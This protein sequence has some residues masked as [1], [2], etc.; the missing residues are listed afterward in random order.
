MRLPGHVASSHVYLIAL[1]NIL[2]WLQC[3]R[4]SAFHDFG[5]ASCAAPRQLHDNQLHVPFKIIWKA[6]M[7]VWDM[8]TWV[9]IPYA[10]T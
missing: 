1:L 9:I 5:A 6:C 7:D 3:I 10:T 4:P 8:V 2:P